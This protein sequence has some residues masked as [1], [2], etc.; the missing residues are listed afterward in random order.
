MSEQE[1]FDIVDEQ[2]IPTGKT[3][4]RAVAH[5]KGILHRTAHVWVI[6]RNG[7]ATQVLLQRRSAV[8]D[9]WPL[10]LDTSS[11]GHILAGDEPKASA[12]RELAEELGIQTEPE[13]LKEAGTFRI[14]F[15]EMFHGRLFYDNEIAFL[16]VYEKPVELKD[17]V[18]QEEEV[19]EA[20]WMDLEEVRSRIESGDP[21]ICADIKSVRLLAE[22]IQEHS[23]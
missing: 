1:L 12:L 14:C 7:P 8:K 23:V 22:Y 20:V 6:R 17:L 10:C 16:Y 2:G 19:T 3:V 21:E 11:A 9:S 5:E 15:R 13:D 18:L 4:I